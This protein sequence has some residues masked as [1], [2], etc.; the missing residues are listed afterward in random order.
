VPQFTL[1][2][3]CLRGNR[4]DF[5]ESADYQTGAKLFE[6]LKNFCLTNNYKNIEFGFFREFMEVKLLNNGPVTLIIETSEKIKR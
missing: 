2:G 5:L 1:Y 4:P 3:N 6:E